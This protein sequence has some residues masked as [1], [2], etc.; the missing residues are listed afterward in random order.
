MIHTMVHES[1]LERGGFLHW[2][3][4]WVFSLPTQKCSKSGILAIVLSFS[5]DFFPSMKVVFGV[6]VENL[7]A[8]VLYLDIVVMLIFLSLMI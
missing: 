1:A 3:S 7:T 8:S 4:V 6:L 5:F 2:F